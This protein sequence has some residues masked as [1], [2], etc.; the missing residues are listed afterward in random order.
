MKKD[1]F[2]SVRPGISG[3]WVCN[4]RNNVSYKKRM[5]YELDYVKK[6]SL[7]FDIKLFFKTI[8]CVIFQRGVS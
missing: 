1:L 6:Y 2:L 7:L 8:Y 3:N 5:K 4:G